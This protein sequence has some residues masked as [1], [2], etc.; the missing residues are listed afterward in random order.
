MARMK[1]EIREA[2]A[3]KVGKSERTVLRMVNRLIEESGFTI[4]DM[5][6]GGNILASDLKVPINQYLSK[7]ELAEVREYRRQLVARPIAIQAKATSKKK[8]ISIIRIGNEIVET[9]GLPDNIGREAVRMSWVYPHFY[10]FENVLRYI[11]MDTLGNKHGENWWN[12]E[13]VVSTSIR[14]E[15]ARRMKNEEKQKWHGV[16]RGVHEIFYTNLRHLGSIIRNNQEEFE[17]IFSKKINVILA[18]L[19]ETED[20][21]NIIAHNNPLPSHE[22]RRIKMYYDD[23]KRI[24]SSQKAK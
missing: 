4:P 10:V 21:R 20:I 14:R 18:K 22:I 3:K 6:V 11:I 5:R 8:E 9:F 24:V 2:I 7:E 23:L 16:K 19:D 17:K 12:T 15:V 1:K 13:G